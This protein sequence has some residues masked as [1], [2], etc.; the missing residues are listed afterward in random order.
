MAEGK[1]YAGSVVVVCFLYKRGAYVALDG[2]VQE[3]GDF[4]SNTDNGLIH[5]KEANGVLN[6]GKSTKGV[7]L[8]A[9]FCNMD[10]RLYHPLLWVIRQIK[11]LDEFLIQ[12]RVVK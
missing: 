2:D 5:D 6:D 12:I 9:S 10:L 3:F 4:W 11:S 1:V 8:V 7:I